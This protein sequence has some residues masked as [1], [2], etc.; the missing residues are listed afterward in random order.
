MTDTEL[1]K[2]A[3]KIVNA[4]DEMRKNNDPADTS[5]MVKINKK[6][7]MEIVC[8]R[9]TEDEID[10]DGGLDP[11]Y[12]GQAYGFEL[13]LIS[14]GIYKDCCSVNVSDCITDDVRWLLECYR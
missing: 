13:Y 12:L 14:N 2:S 10:D 8:N 1:E 7:S 5:R 6:L 4:F 9:F 11:E 3:R